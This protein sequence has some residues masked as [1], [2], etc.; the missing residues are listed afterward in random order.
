[1]TSSYLEHLGILENGSLKNFRFSLRI[2]AGLYV[3]DQ[4]KDSKT[5]STNST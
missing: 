2:K 4:R 3:A 5:F 1:M